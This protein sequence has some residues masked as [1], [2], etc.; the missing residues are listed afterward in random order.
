MENPQKIN[1][2]SMENQW[3]ISGKSV[4]NPWK[5]NGK[6]IENQRKIGGKSVEN[7][8][9]PVDLGVPYFQ[10]QTHINI[11][12]I[13]DINGFREPKFWGLEEK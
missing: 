1:G 6:S 8:P 7:H 3:K 2:K 4:E 11:H 10:T 5:I 13:N 9:Y 12:Y